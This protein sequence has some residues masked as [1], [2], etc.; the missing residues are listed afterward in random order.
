MS[1]Q[2]PRQPESRPSRRRRAIHHGLL[3]LGASLGGAH[4]CSPPPDA[5]QTKLAGEVRPKEKTRVLVAPIEVREML[6]T[7]T[8]TTDVESKNEIEVFPRTAGV[9]VEVRVEE[10][11]RVEA[12]Q[13]LAVLDQRD[14]L[15][16]LADAEM[17]LR[18]ARESRP[19]LAISKSDAE[20]RVARAKL[21]WE[22]AVRDVERNEGAGLISQNELDRIAL[23]RDQ[24]FRDHETSKLAHAT[25]VQDVKAG[26]TAVDRAALAV[27]RAKLM[28]SYTEIVAPFAGSIAARTIKVGDSV[29]AAAS[30]FVLTDPENLRAIF[31]RPQ[32][33]LPLFQRSRAGMNGEGGDPIEITVTAEAIPDVT[34]AGTIELISPTIDPTNGSFRITVALEQPTEESGRARLAP[35]MLVRLAIVTE[36]HEK[37][38]VVPKRAVLR[39]GDATVVFVIADGVAH[40]VPV[41]EGFSNDASVELF[42]ATP[43]GLNVGDLVV[44]VGNR[45]LE[46]GSEVIAEPWG[47]AA[48]ADSTRAD[49]GAAESR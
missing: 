23:T 26:A 46:E 11:D 41:R 25:C 9:A 8:T 27:E 32:R 45:D 5:P 48:E 1:I 4:A 44:V 3:A 18:V 22:Q 7:L 29:S 38:L 13:V 20:E 10:A 21:T 14:A 40:R 19:K 24:A 49:A 28:L 31:G 17:E 12:G 35:G 2:A 34:F 43:G 16:G 47:E 33:E 15:A 37:A 39:E 30:A 36:R 6:R 42:A